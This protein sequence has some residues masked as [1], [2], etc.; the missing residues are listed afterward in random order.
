MGKQTCRTVLFSMRLYDGDCSGF[1]VCGSRSISASVQISPECLGQVLAV[2]A[3]VAFCALR[4]TLPQ[5]PGL[6]VKHG[7]S[8]QKTHRQIRTNMDLL[9]SLQY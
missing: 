7:Y 6:G 1:D 3:A 2:V 4:L 5:S 8:L 9:S